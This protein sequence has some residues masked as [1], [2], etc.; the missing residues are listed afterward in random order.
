LTGENL[1]LLWVL[2]PTRDVVCHCER[3]AA[4]SSLIWFSSGWC[5]HQ[6]VSLR[7]ENAH[8]TV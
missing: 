2:L 5:Y 7:C 8:G 3:S 4:I 6:P 1:L